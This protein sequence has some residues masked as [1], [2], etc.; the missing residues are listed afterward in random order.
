MILGHRLDGD[1]FQVEVS[2][3]LAQ[4]PLRFTQAV[5]PSVRPDA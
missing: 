5:K 2:A 1:L 4:E 3:A